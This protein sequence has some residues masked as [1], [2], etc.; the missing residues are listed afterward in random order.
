MVFRPPASLS[1]SIDA[2][3]PHLADPF[4]LAPR[5]LCGGDR[6]LVAHRHGVVASDVWPRVPYGDAMALA[7]GEDGVSSC[8]V[9]AVHAHRGHRG[10]RSSVAR[11]RRALLRVEAICVRYP[12]VIADAFSESHGARASLKS[13]VNVSEPEFGAFDAA[14]PCKLTVDGRLPSTSCSR[15]RRIRRRGPRSLASSNRRCSRLPKRTVGTSDDGTVDLFS[16]VSCVHFNI[17]GFL[18]HMHELD[19]L[20]TEL[21]RPGIV[22]LTETFLDES[23]D[24]IS[25]SEYVLISRRDRNRN[26]GGI[27]LFAHVSIAPH[28]VHVGNSAI[29]E[30]AW[31]VLHTDQG[32]V[33]VCLW[34]RPPMR[35]EVD[36]IACFDDELSI[37][38]ADCSF[39]MVVGDMN[40]HNIEWLAHSSVNSPEG[41]ELH[42]VCC[43]HGL[44]QYV[45]EPTRESHLLDLVLSDCDDLLK[46]K[47]IP[48]LSD[49][50]GVLASLQLSAPE[51]VEI[52]RLCFNYAKADWGSMRD[53]FKHT[54]WEAILLV[55]EEDVDGFAKALAD[56]ILETVKQYTPNRV[57]RT[58]KST[59]PWLDEHC[60]A[61]IRE[62][63]LA[64]G[65]P[66]FQ[67][68][69]D[70]CTNVL[71]SAFW[72]YV[73]KTK[74]ELCSMA[75]S[76]K[77]WL[78]QANKLM[79]KASG[80]S[81]VPPLRRQDGSWAR[82]GQAKAE[83]LSQT[84]ASKA[85]LPEEVSNEYT[86]LDVSLDG[87]ENSFVHVDEDSVLKVLAK[88]R[89]DSGTGPDESQSLGKL[90]L[91]AQRWQ[92]G[93]R[94]RRPSK[95][96][97]ATNWP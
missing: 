85:A 5:I 72:R 93:N 3:P 63:H 21:Q 50:K 35:G 56:Y 75:P 55:D 45:R 52:K 17:R 48:G 15:L 31:H 41:R 12:L 23:V 54:D 82:E 46:V 91:R 32:P 33:G 96:G 87:L 90:N 27:A 53:A 76:S 24:D 6:S 74:D 43:S 61:A 59:H 97:P 28:I 51:T 65:V 20:L 14:A 7:C 81:S 57:V 88:L 19:A 80:V 70:Q 22:A 38:S 49:H 79:M 86:P 1:T 42:D 78:K 30:L 92:N 47:V 4:S 77:Q 44:H 10:R 11:R 66:N 16:D 64:Y 58:A 37:Y 94:R 39:T 60:R 26:G 83:L 25:L 34:Y 67:E 36:S 29:H 89:E 68:K 18:S 8:G 40:V 71:Q 69:R 2:R 13:F 84:F 62:K 73:A 9:L 95:R